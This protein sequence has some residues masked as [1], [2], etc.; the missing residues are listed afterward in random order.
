MAQTNNPGL[1]HVLLRDALR[2]GG[3]AIVL[4]D[5]VAAYVEQAHPKFAADLRA[6]GVRYHRTMPEQTDSSSA[7]GSSW[8]TVFKAESRAEAEEAL[9]A[10][11]RVRRLGVRAARRR[12]LGRGRRLRAG[13]P[14]RHRRA[15]SLRRRR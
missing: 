13:P 14:R 9:A 1:H 3:G 2:G 12:G 4:S 5:E 6:H 15:R 8:R 10:G 11:G 7:R